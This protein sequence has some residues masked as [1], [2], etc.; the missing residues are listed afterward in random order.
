MFKD[1]YEFIYLNSRLTKEQAWD[2]ATDCW[3][4]GMS[5]YEALAAL[6]ER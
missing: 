1:Y 6:N 2:Y 4:K 5:K 3:N